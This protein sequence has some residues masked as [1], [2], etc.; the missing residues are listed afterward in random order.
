MSQ[1]R[2]AERTVYMDVLRVLASF[3]VIMIHVACVYLFERRITARAWRVGSVYNA[4]SR[5]CVPVFFMLSGALMLSPEKKLSIKRL[6]GKNILRLAAALVF[7]G[8]LYD[9]AQHRHALVFPQF[10]RDFLYFLSD[11]QDHLWFLPAMIGCYA[12]VPLLRCLCARREILRY[13]AAF[14]VVFIFATETL[15]LLLPGIWLVQMLDQLNP[16]VF[17]YPTAYMVIGYAFHT[18]QLK[19]EHKLIICLLGIAATAALILGVWQLH[20]VMDDPR[21]E[22]LYA[23]SQLPVFMQSMAVYVGVR[24]VTEK[25]RLS[26]KSCRGI[27]KLAKYSFGCYLLHM[28]PIY[29][30]ITPLFSR[31]PFTLIVLIPLLSAAVFAVCMA[32]SALLNR[33]PWVNRYLV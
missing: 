29:Y 2:P 9:I 14:S 33:I 5:F 10:F 11:R 31:P 13:C 1:S 27:Q 12:A 20:D 26:E 4:L 24:H 8:F 30:V 6:F 28:F 23:Y 3:A 15:R 22:Q 18:A 7:W 16:S 25:I 17:V 32:V 21:W 19:K